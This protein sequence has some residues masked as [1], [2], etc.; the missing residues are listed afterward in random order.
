MIPE[1]LLA[2]FK[3]LGVASIPG[4]QTNTRIFE[5]QATVGN[6]SDDETPWCAAFVQWCL[7]R[8]GIIGTGHA[9]AKSY[10]EWGID[11]GSARVGSILVMNRGS[12]SWQGHVSFVIQDNGDTVYA[13]GG[14]QSGRVKISCYKKADIIAYRL[15]EEKGQNS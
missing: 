12:Q 15:P 6:P 9:Q 2:A 3:E 13:L 7:S 1:Y 8:A 14:N 5:Y 4:P 10:L 11:A